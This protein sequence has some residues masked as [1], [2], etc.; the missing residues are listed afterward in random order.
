MPSSTEIS[1]LSLH[2]ALPIW[3]GEE[4][5]GSI[6]APL[7]PIP[8]LGAVAGSATPPIPRSEEH[9]SE[10]QSLR[11]LVCRLP[12]RSPLF[13]Y[14]TLFRSGTGRSCREAFPLRSRPF[15]RLGPW[16]AAQPRPS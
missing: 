4:L 12:P 9:T 15:L 6:P 8:A 1:S 2:D 5:P 10:L 14:T 13:P 11:H 16:P 3:D 7:A